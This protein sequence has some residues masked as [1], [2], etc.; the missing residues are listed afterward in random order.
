M[1]IDFDYPV[2]MIL[3]NSQIPEGE[4]DK[5]EKCDGHICERGPLKSNV[6]PNIYF[7]MK[8]VK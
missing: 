5:W 3:D 1:S 6:I 4:E 7:M 2:G 8:V